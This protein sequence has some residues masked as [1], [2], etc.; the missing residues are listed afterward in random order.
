MTNKEFFQ[1]CWRSEVEPTLI[2]LRALPPEDQQ[3]YKPAE[4]NRTAK[5]LVDHFVSHVDDLVEAAESGVLNHRL[6]ADFPTT[7]GA[8]EAFEKGSEKLMSLL[9]ATNDQT[10]D[11]KMIPMMVFG[12]KFGEKPLGATCWMFLF[13]LVHHRGQLSTYYRPMGVKQPAIYGPTAEMVEE[14]MAKSN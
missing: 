8:I 4:K 10:W 9:D 2:A 14:M 5:Q 3:G 7:A 12:N 11:E 13:D 6:M 1:Q